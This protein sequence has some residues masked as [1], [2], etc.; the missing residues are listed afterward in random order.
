VLLLPFTSNGEDKS[1]KRVRL[2]PES[3]HGG[4]LLILSPAFLWRILMKQVFAALA[5]LPPPSK[6]NKACPYV[7]D[8]AQIKTL[9]AAKVSE[10]VR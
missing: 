4:V 3:N 7:C 6:K 9:Q 5:G 8:I 1:R 10:R 2:E